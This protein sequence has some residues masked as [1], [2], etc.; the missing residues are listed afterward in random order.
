METQK[1]DLLKRTDEILREVTP[2]TSDL[3]LHAGYYQIKGHL[4][5]Y[6]REGLGYPVH[7]ARAIVA[8][9]SNMLL[10]MDL[11]PFEVASDHTKVLKN[12]RELLEI[13][14]TQLEG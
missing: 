2:V 12:L 7:S 6:Y 1:K 13:W 5:N 3:L 14:S 10:Y 9:T 8:L 11:Q 4:L